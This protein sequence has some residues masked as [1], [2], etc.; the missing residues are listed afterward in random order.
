M[1]KVFENIPTQMTDSHCITKEGPG[2][3]SYQVLGPQEESRWAR[4]RKW[5]APGWG[6]EQDIPGS[7]TVQPSGGP[8]YPSC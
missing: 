7:P 4:G 1:G 5:V 6:K 2:A 8:M 3:G